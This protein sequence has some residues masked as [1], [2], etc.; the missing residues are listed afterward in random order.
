MATSY[1]TYCA[2]I[3]TLNHA[4]DYLDAVH[5]S[6]RRTPD[7]CVLIENAIYAVRD[8]FRADPENVGIELPTSPI[9]YSLTRTMRPDFTRNLARSSY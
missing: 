6:T 4:L 3:V 9:C 8:E 1:C 5:G 2:A 7:D